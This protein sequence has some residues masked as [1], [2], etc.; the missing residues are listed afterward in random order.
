MLGIGILKFN[1][2]FFCDYGTLGGHGNSA[3]V[4]EEHGY[5]ISYP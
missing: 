2:E 3:C 1:G 4:I 5:T